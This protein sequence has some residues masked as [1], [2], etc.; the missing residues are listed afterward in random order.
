MNSIIVKAL[1]LLIT[2]LY[3]G[4]FISVFNVKTSQIPKKLTDD[5]TCNERVIY[6]NYLLGLRQLRKTTKNIPNIEAM[7]SFIDFTNNYITNTPLNVSNTEINNREVGVKKLIL[8]NMQVDVSNIKYIHI[9]T[10]KDVL[11][12]ELDKKNKLINILK[13]INNVDT[14]INTM[15]MILKIANIS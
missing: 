10:K 14:F 8:A 13:D 7:I 11:I 15:S 5:N 1:V 2:I 12:V 3:S 4:A 9:H 6:K